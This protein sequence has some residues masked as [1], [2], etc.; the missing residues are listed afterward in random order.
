[1]KV[2]G[3]AK[4]PRRD[5]SVEAGTK[6]PRLHCVYSRGDFFSAADVQVARFSGRSRILLKGEATCFS[7]EKN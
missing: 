2:G 4:V 5:W 3:A 7:T 1:M 6:P